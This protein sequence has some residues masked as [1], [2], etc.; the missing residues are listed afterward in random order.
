[1]EKQERDESLVAEPRVEASDGGERRKEK[2]GTP[3]VTEICLYTFIDMRAHT[4][5]R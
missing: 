1:M 4:H 5:R 3:S 2:P